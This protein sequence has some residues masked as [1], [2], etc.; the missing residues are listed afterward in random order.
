LS[1][2]VL[3]EA[4]RA[5]LGDAFQPRSDIDAAAHAIAV[6]PLHQVATWMPTRNSIRRS[7]G[8]L[9]DLVAAFAHGD[10]KMGRNLSDR[11]ARSDPTANGQKDKKREQFPHSRLRLGW[12]D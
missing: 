3:G 10:V 2:C 7:S 6:A 4:D 12:M 8:I 1:V 5:R 11:H 9:P